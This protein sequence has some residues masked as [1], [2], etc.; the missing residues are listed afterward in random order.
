MRVVF[1]DVSLGVKCADRSYIFSYQTA[2]LESLV[3]K[4]REWIFRAP[5]PTFWRATTDNDRG[6]GFSLK[7][8]MWLGADMFIK[9]YD[10]IV[11]VDGTILTKRDLLAPC[12]NKLFDSPL[13]EAAEVNIKYLYKTATLPEADVCVSYHVNEEGMK[14]N[15]VYNGAEGLPELPVVGLRFIL[16]FPASSFT[17]TGLS[18]ET[19]PDRMKGGVEGTY[20]VEGM[21]VTQYIVPQECGM[22][23]ESSCVAIK[24]GD[25]E[26]T[27]SMV[28]KKFAFS[29]L[30][31]TAEELENA[32]HHEELPLV[33]RSVLVMAAAVRG[34]GGINSWGADTEAP[35]HI[36]GDKSY[37][38]SFKI[39]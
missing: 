39:S 11:D 20:T 7:A 2:G 22:H 4:G 38:L 10:F 18:G 15:F 25:D 32:L 23:M 12:N 27:F 16:P 33:R 28:D 29:L 21:P 30:P 1:G 35:Y 37:S 26:L 34:V 31:Y 19:Y 9:P 36:F 24:S 13:R 14:I 17:Y 8:A 5:K 6:N 3:I